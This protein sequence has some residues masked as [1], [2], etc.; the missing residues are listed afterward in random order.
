[1]GSAHF[2]YKLSFYNGEYKIHL[3]FAGIYILTQAPRGHLPQALLLSWEG[4]EIIALEPEVSPKGEVP[5]GF[6][7]FSMVLPRNPSRVVSVVWVHW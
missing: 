4:A 2:Q 7:N 6:G 3:P 5:I 1:M